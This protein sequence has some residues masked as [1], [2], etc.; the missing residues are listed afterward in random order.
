VTIGTWLTENPR[1]LR[2]QL[3]L[4]ERF[5]KQLKET[6]FSALLRIKALEDAPPAVSGSVVNEY[7]DN[8]FRVLDNA[9]PT[10][11]LAFEVSDVAAS[12]TRTVTVPNADV[13]LRMR[14]AHTYEDFLDRAVSATASTNQTV[15]GRVMFWNALVGNWSHVI[16]SL[17]T[18][19]PG[20]LRLGLPA[21][22]NAV[23]CVNCCPHRSRGGEWMWVA[24][25]TEATAFTG[26]TK[27]IGFFSVNTASATEPVDGIYLWQTAGTAAHGF[28]T[29]S[30]S[31]RTAG[32]TANL[33]LN[34]WYTMGVRMNDARTSVDCILLDDTGATVL[35]YSIA[36]NIP[37]N[38]V[39]LYAQA[40]VS[41]SGTANTQALD[42]D[43]IRVRLGSPGNGLTRPV[44]PGDWTP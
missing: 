15:I 6:L 39:V 23:A 4:F 20:I 14:F 13:D 30:A 27:K 17:Q 34:T 3:S 19:H 33:S 41:T 18:E 5:V 9:T 21:T 24:F 26:L 35:S 8:V 1:E 12:T 36:T 16:A 22:A 42:V 7:P 10:K 38:T 11:K 37:A 32:A 43:M 44:P 40:S 2:R 29:S 28:K 31:V 25:R